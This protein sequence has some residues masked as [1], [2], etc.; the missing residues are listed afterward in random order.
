MII[1]FDETLQEHNNSLQEVFKKLREYNLQLEPDKCEFLKRELQYLGHIVT[2][3]GISPNP[4][5]IQATVEFPTP[6]TPKS[7]K[8]FLGLV[9]Y[10][11]RFIPNF[12]RMA[13]PRNDLVK[14]TEAWKWELEQEE[15][16]RELN[17]HITKPPVLQFP[18]FTQPFVLFSYFSYF[19]VWAGFPEHYDP[20]ADP[21]Y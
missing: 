14:K 15:S 12:S 8:S 19:S 6:E 4:K 17:E 5:K 18:D 11:R 7:V 1:T 10:Y 3:D 20:Y 13:K 16:F 21:L 2:A 9:G